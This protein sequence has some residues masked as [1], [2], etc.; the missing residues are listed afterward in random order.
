M[1]LHPVCGDCTHG[2][3]CSRQ[4]TRK[5][6]M[7]RLPRHYLEKY[8]RILFT[9]RI[10][11]NNNNYCRVN[12]GNEKLIFPREKLFAC[13]TRIKFNGWSKIVRRTLCRKILYLKKIKIFDVS[14]NNFSH[15]AIHE[16]TKILMEFFKSSMKTIITLKKK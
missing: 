9:G 2:D 12:C 3:A 10:N 16:W 11:N 15:I 14:G 8:R 6:W 13:Q 1:I 7:K 5:P 4:Y